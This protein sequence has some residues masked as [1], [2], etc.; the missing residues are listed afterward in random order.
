[1]SCLAFS[2]RLSSRLGYT[3]TSCMLKCLLQEL[4][5]K[6]ASAPPQPLRRISLYVALDL[7]E[8]FGIKEK[9]TKPHLAADVV[10]SSVATQT[11]DFVPQ[12]VNTASSTNSA[13]CEVPFQTKMPQSTNE[14]WTQTFEQLLSEQQCKALF[15][16]SEESFRILTEQMAELQ[17]RLV[18]LEAPDICRDAKVSVSSQVPALTHEVASGCCETQGWHA[19]RHQHREERL[20]LKQQRRMERSCLLD[21]GGSSSGFE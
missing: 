11:D 10:I 6:R 13:R 4:V 9:V 12:D 19:L 7:E 18:G 14:E 5:D 2:V 3:T 8:Q 1:M 17:E 21:P 16:Q 20:M 15:R